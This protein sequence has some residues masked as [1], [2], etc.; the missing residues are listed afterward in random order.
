MTRDETIALFER[1]ETA[2]AEVLRDGR[3]SD[4][5]HAAATKVW[6]TWA[7]SMLTR[8]KKLQQRGNWYLR[9]GDVALAGQTQQTIDWLEDAHANFSGYVFKETADFRNFIFPGPTNFGF[10]C[11][12]IDNAIDQSNQKWS[13]RRMRGDFIR[14]IY[15]PGSDVQF[16]QDALF[17]DAEFLGPANFYGAEFCAGGDFQ[18]AQFKDIAAFDNSTFFIRGDFDN[19]LFAKTASFLMWASGKVPKICAILGMRS[20]KTFDSKEMHYFS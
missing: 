17:S 9:M 10:V 8:K 19:A 15:A 3:G 16:L 14:G 12:L 20:L 13:P 6:N 1:C 11:E 2:R 18:R 5:A 7:E 4:A